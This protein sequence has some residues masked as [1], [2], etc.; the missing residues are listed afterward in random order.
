QQLHGGGARPDTDVI[1]QCSFAF[2]AT[3]QVLH[4]NFATRRER[5]GGSRWQPLGVE[6]GI[7]RG[8]APF[9]LLIGLVRRDAADESRESPRCREGPYLGMLEVCFGQ[10]GGEAVGKGLLELTQRFRRQL[11]SPDLDEKVALP[12]VSRP[13]PC[14]L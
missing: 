14:A 9:D 5:L 7:N 3:L 11:L 2:L 13:R 10:T 1:K 8:A 4:R 6:C 12:G